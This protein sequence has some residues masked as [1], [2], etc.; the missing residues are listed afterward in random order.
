MGKFCLNRL[1]NRG[2]KIAHL[3][4]FHQNFIIFWN[5]AYRWGNKAQEANDP[6]HGMLSRFSTFSILSKF[7][8]LSI[9]S[10]VKF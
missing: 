1:T 10:N 3:F 7:S 4:S 9:F 6:F 8:M 5:G 2:Y